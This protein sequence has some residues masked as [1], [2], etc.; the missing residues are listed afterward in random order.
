[1]SFISDILKSIDQYEREFYPKILVSIKS[2]KEQD[3]I[4][5]AIQI[6]QDVSL[7]YALKLKADIG[8]R[9]S[10]I[11]LESKLNDMFPSWDPVTIILAGKGGNETKAAKITRSQINNA[12]NFGAIAISDLMDVQT[13][14]VYNKTANGEI[15]TIV[16][17]YD[18]N[19]KVILKNP[20]APEPDKITEQVMPGLAGVKQVVDEKMTESAQVIMEQFNQQ[21]ET[22]VNKI[23]E[24]ITKIDGNNSDLSAMLQQNSEGIDALKNYKAPPVVIEDKKVPVIVSEL[25]RQISERLNQIES[26][27]NSKEYNP[28]ITVNSPDITMPA[29]MINIET[30]TFKQVV[31][32]EIKTILNMLFRVVEL[33]NKP[34]TWVFDVVYK[35]E[36]PIKITA[37]EQ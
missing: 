14:F 10:Q 9:I 4:D 8:V 24:L 32:D 7:W 37:T 26:L 27:V 29:P 33:I 1:M 12:L 13:S 17:N 2:G 35:N 15:L 11:R 31:K 30:D 19:G 25:G 34:S 36:L 28:A 5:L 3:T 23:G 22:F 6:Y 21:S 20:P 18:I 16:E